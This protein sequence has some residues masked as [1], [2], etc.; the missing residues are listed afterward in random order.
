[1][2]STP[3]DTPIGRGAVERPL[4]VSAAIAAA[5][6]MFAGFAPTYYLKSAFG[7]PDLDAFRHLHG[8]VM[9]TWFALFLAQ[10]WLAASGR[11]RLHR[12]L[13]AAGIVLAI[14]VL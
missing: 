3:L 1:M 9:T 13:G 12:Q 4:Y 2:A 10:A 14:V 6:I 11:I 7:T 8:A 5:L